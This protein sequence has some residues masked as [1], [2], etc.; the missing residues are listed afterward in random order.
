MRDFTRRLRPVSNARQAFVVWLLFCENEAEG[1]FR[2]CG[3]EC[4]SVMS[5]NLS[6]CFINRVSGRTVADQAVVFNR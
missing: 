1:S 5:Y 6:G 3:I 4:Y 2:P